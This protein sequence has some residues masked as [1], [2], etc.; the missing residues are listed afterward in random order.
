[1]LDSS[2]VTINHRICLVFSKLL[3][4][5]NQNLDELHIL[6]KSR[7]IYLCYDA[8]HFIKNV[9]NN[10][11]KCER[12]IFPPFEFSEFKDPVNVPGG[13]TAWKTFHDIFERHANLHASLKKAPK[14][15]TKVL[16]AGNCKQN[17]PNALT[18]FGETTIATV[19]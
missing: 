19:K 7:K 9:R 14:L 5:V 18:I 11:L 10:L 13:E 17:V 8:V 3:E 4:H 12:F 6:H 1:M 15:T 16:H 2:F